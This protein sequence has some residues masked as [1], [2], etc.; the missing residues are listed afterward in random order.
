MELF[1]I[2]IK[3]IQFYN[4]N[5]EFKYNDKFT[6]QH[7]DDKLIRILISKK[8]KKRAQQKNILKIQTN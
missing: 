5:I 2:V 6:F 7:F 8:K 1:F 4:S 3:K